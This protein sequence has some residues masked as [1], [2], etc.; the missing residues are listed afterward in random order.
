MRSGSAVQ[1]EPPVQPM[2]RTLDSA[3]NTADGTKMARKI[4]ATLT[5]EAWLNFFSMAKMCDLSS[6]GLLRGYFAEVLFE[7]IQRARPGSCVR[8]R[9]ISLPAAAVKTVRRV[10]IVE[11]LVRFAEFSQLGAKP[12]HFVRRWILIEL[13]KVALN[14][15]GDVGCQSRRGRAF[16]PLL[17]GAAA[18][19]VHGGFAW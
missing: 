7:K 1:A 18:V 16:A 5:Q 9:S 15:A 2:L 8:F 6:R 17:I 13:A 11:K 3:A 14:R 4:A 12:A 10:G 19:E